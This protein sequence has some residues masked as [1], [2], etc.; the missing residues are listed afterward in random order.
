MGRHGIYARVRHPLRAGTLLEFLGLAFLTP[1]V[2][3]WLA[4]AL[5]AAWVL[6]QTKLEGADLLQGAPGYR[7]CAEQVPCFVPRL[8]DRVAG[9][10]DQ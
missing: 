3:V 10:H 9:D 2:S 1:T 6:V 7:E 5:R 8:R 4:S